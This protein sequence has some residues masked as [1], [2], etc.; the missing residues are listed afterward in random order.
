MSDLPDRPYVEQPELGYAAMSYAA[1]VSLICGVLSSLVLVRLWSF[2]VFLVF[3]AVAV[4]CGLVGYRRVTRSEGAL[5][6]KY[7]A[8]VGLNLGLIFG[9]IG[10]AVPTVDYL[11]ARKIATELADRFVQLV[12]TGEMADAYRMTGPEY[13]RDR[14]FSQFATDVCIQR[15]REGGTLKNVRFSY[16]DRHGYGASEKGEEFIVAGFETELANDTVPF[17]LRAVKRE[18]WQITGVEPP[19]APSYLDEMRR[20]EKEQ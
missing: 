19:P 9:A 1:V 13:Q 5:A 2:N 17:V 20:R 14:P 12:A 7:V 3:P 11:R 18:G 4:V 16:M 10:L 6:G 15:L 8:M